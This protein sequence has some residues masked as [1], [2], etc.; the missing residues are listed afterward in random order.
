MMHENTDMM[1][2]YLN[3]SCDGEYNDTLVF[4]I[5]VNTAKLSSLLKNTEGF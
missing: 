2:R 5:G 1:T 3:S 4:W